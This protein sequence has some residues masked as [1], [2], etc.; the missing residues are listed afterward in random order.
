M[1]IKDLHN[2]LI[3]FVSDD[4]VSATRFSL[5]DSICI[6]TCL[7][8]VL[9]LWIGVVDPEGIVPLVYGVEVLVSAYHSFVCLRLNGEVNGSNLF[10][11]DLDKQDWR[12][13]YHTLEHSDHSHQNEYSCHANIFWSRLFGLFGTQVAQDSRQDSAAFELLVLVFNVS[14]QL[15]LLKAHAW[16][17]CQC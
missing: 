8:I 5:E 10:L 2:C 16:S 1:V 4:N 17:H 11:S 12:A 9:D 13:I 7:S 15:F 14:E 6:L 3:I